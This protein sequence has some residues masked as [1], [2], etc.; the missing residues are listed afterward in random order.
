M[1]LCMMTSYMTAHFFN[2]SLYNRALRGKQI[3]MLKDFVPEINKNLL[4]IVIM[5]EEVVSIS[6]IP[7]VE[8]IGKALMNG[9]RS[10]PV[11]N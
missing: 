1:L 9:Y 3:P 11:I 2:A 10:F 5:K 6:L 7:T 8:E 4:A